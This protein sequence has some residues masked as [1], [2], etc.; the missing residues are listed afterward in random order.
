MEALRAAAQKFYSSLDAQ[1]WDA[2]GRLV[3]PDFVALVGDGPPMALTTWRERLGTFYE[4]FPDGHH[5]IDEYVVGEQAVATRCRFLG[6][7]TGT[8]QGIEPTGTEVSAGVIHIDHVIDGKIVRHHGQ[9][10]MLGLL[11]RLRNAAPS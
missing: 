8:F 6:T 7:H 4:G 3:T 1:D 2:V 5:V 10:D 9:L 11:S